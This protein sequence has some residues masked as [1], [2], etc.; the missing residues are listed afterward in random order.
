MSTTIQDLTIRD[1]IQVLKDLRNGHIGFDVYRDERTSTKSALLQYMLKEFSSDEIVQAIK[2]FK[3]EPKTANSAPLLVAKSP[4]LKAPSDVTDD[5]A[6][7]A[8]LLAKLASNSKQALDVDAVEA[9]I[10]RSIAAYDAT[11]FSEERAYSFVS[12]LIK[13]E[14]AKLERPQVTVVS[15]NNIQTQVTTGMGMQ[16][17]RFPLL[18]QTAQARD[19]QGNML[20]IWLRGPAG[21]GK[22]TAAHNV[23]KALDLKFYSNG[24]LLTEHSL[25]GYK[26]AMGNYHRT[27]FRDAFEHG[28][29]YLGDEADGWNANASLWLQAA[30]ANG[31][32]AF[33]DGMIKRHKDCLIIM[34]ANTAGHGATSEYIARNKIDGATLDRYID[35]Q[36]PIDEALELALCRDSKWC[37]HVQKTRKKMHDRGV[38]GHLITP[39]ASFLGA[40]LL[41]QGL[42]L[43]QVTDQVLRKSLVTESWEQ[44]W[45]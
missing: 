37:K 29:V 40:S 27:V 11:A 1:L 17:F 9:L 31:W 10:K 15:V 44:I 39:R 45:Q 4:A 25:S 12:D 24:T 32:C 21:T 35:F 7:L 14:I 33:P 43:E 18:L 5:A 42:T 19:E 34:G 6:Q 26:D 3:N 30:T 13:Q 36:W 16:H 2:N 20:N 38:K 41:A 23:A 8:I 22:T 28:G